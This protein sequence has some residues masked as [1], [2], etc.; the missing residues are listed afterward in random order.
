MMRR[1][2]RSTLFPYTT[3]FRSAGVEINGVDHIAVNRNPNARLW[4][5]A[6]FILAKR[7]SIGAIRRR[8]ANRAKIADLRTEIVES[9]K[10]HGLKPALHNVEHHRAHLASA[11]F[12]APFDDAA[13]LSVDGFG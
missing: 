5:R 7:P 11:F 3:L 13:I 6:K 10:L 12:V 9:F 2:P 4:Q 1:P 8:L